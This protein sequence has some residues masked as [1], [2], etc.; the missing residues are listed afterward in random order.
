V[1]LNKCLRD[2]DDEV[3]ERAFF[4][5]RLLEEQ[6]E[7]SCL[8]ADFEEITVEESERED[9]CNFVFDS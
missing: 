7:K 1:L 2:S 6:G 8:S 9:I 5:I 3:R 4:F